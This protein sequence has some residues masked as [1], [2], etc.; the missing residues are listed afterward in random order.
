MSSPIVH[1]V[2]MYAIAAIIAFLV[3]LLIK[4]MSASLGRFGR[5]PGL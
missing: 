1:A 2:I 5:K 3:A 4:G